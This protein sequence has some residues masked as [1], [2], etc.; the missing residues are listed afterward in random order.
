MPEFAELWG[1][2]YWS[3]LPTDRRLRLL[4]PDERAHFDAKVHEIPEIPLIFGDF[5]TGDP[6]HDMPYTQ[7]GFLFVDNTL[8]EHYLSAR[9]Y[10]RRDDMA[11]SVLL[12][13]EQGLPYGTHGRLYAFLDA[14]SG[15]GSEYRFVSLAKEARIK[16]NPFSAGMTMGGAVLSPAL[17]LLHELLHGV[18]WSQDSIAHTLRRIT[19]SDIAPNMEEEVTLIQERMIAKRIGEGNREFH[20]GYFTR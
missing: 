11:Q 9:E 4:S 13:Y 8:V 3:S 16:W 5:Q 14:S 7:F 15:E 2:P 19:L 17:I 10:L 1:D 12:Q 6:R 18:H 20:G